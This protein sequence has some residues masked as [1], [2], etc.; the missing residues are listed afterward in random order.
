M[1]SLA[2]AVLG[3]VHRGLP[4][5]Y[6]IPFAL[7]VVGLWLLTLLADRGQRLALFGFL[8]AWFVGAMTMMFG[9]RDVFVARGSE[10]DGLR[11]VRGFRLGAALP[12]LVLLGSVGIAAS[13][14]SPHGSMPLV[15]P[16]LP[17]LVAPFLVPIVFL[18]LLG[19]GVRPK[20]LVVW[21]AVFASL[22][23][24][25]GVGS[26]VALVGVGERGPLGLEDT[27]LPLMA[28]VLRFI[29][30]VADTDSGGCSRNSS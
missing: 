30:M 22:V 16:L 29:S 5:N 2:R 12:A 9:M 11:G 24:L 7:S 13:R 1:N 25:V 18:S 28:L 20:V 4:P 15:L 23:G 3:G 26:I 21:A 14:I 27:G 8:F 10:P 6:R 19:I 17:V